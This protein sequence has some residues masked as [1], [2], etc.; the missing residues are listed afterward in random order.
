MHI[1][2]FIF[3]LLFTLM[4]FAINAQV[5][6]GKALSNKNSQTIVSHLDASVDIKVEKKQDVY[7]QKQAEV[8]INDF[9]KKHPISSFKIKHESTSKNGVRFLVGILVSGNKRYQLTL[10]YTEN[11]ARKIQSFSVSSE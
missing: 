11:G 9:F 4:S 1:P 3:L 7:S 8:I 6:F 2:K 10:K 5:H